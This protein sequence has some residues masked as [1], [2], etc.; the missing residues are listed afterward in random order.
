MKNVN[1]KCREGNVGLERLF[2]GYSGV[3]SIQGYAVSKK[4]VI[5]LKR[6]GW[7]RGPREINLGPLI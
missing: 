5:G 6:T 7:E 4:N 2:L 1:K 3:C